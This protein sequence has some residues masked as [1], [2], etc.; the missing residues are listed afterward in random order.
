[1]NSGRGEL[2]EGV[3]AEVS[4][5]CELMEGSEA[6]FLSPRV[7]AAH[8]RIIKIFDEWSEVEQSRL[9]LMHPAWAGL[10]IRLLN[11]NETVHIR[12]ELAYVKAALETGS[13]P[14]RSSWINPGFFELLARQVERWNS[15]D[16]LIKEDSRPIV[17]VGG[18]ALP[19][20]QVIL[21][22][23][24]GMT[25]VSIERHRDSA[26]AARQLIEHL[27]YDG[28]LK[29]IDV[30]GREYDYSGAAIVVVA[31]MV[32]EKVDVARRVRQSAPDAYLNI[33]TPN[34]LHGLWRTPIGARDL[35]SLGWRVV[36]TWLPEKSAVS[37]FTCVARKRSA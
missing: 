25:V 33:R 2:I 6:T 20:S 16:L 26:L 17:V 36:D 32:A 24:T 19:Q 1:M 29:V 37:A 28:N 11:A 21:H 18:G 14:F 3:I 4:F 12:S 31:A 23:H 8:D 22:R 30:D 27:G 9:L 7:K 34:N 5:C 35:N 10:R 15:L 13:D